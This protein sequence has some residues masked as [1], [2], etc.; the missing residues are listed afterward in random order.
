MLAF[1]PTDGMLYISRGDGGTTESQD[2]DSPF[3]KLLRIDVDE[4]NAGLPYGIPDGNL[5]DEVW[6]IGLRNPWRFSF[7][8]CI[9]DIYIGDVGE[10]SFEEIDFE[11]AGVVGLN[12]GWK[13]GGP[14]VLRGR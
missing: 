6:S 14:A 7:D 11:P 10:A 13:R 9:G 3:G 12:H 8:A 4:Q 1:G 5:N 2:L